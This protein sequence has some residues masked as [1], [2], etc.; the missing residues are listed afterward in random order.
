MVKRYRV[1]IQLALVFRSTLC[2]TIIDFSE[3]S[4]PAKLLVEN[5][6]VIAWIKS[7]TGSF[8]TAS[9]IM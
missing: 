6:V 5:D 9:F 1:K 3:E 7:N 8:Q 2:S 4:L